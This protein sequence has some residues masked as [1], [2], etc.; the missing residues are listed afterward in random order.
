MADRSQYKEALPHYAAAILLMFGA[1]GLV[2]ILFGD[3]GFAIEAVIAIV[4]ATVYFM[5]VR[6]LGYAP[7]MWQ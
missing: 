7:R 4:V 5:A 1:L 2:N 3:V 6:W